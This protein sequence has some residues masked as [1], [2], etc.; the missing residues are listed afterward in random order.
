[1]DLHTT[2]RHARRWLRLGVVLLVVVA[3]ISPVAVMAAGGAFTDDDTSIFEA[4]IEWL[5]D[6]G[7]TAGC[8]P[9]DNDYFC[10]G[11]AVTRGQMAAF[12]RRLSANQVVDAGALGGETA[13]HFEN[14]VWANDVEGLVADPF[15]G[16]N[17][18]WVQLTVETTAPGFLLINATTSLYDSTSAGSALFWIQVDVPAC[19]NVPDQLYSVGYA[20]GYVPED[21]RQSV[22]ITGAAVVDA[23]THT[24]T[25]CGRSSAGGGD[26]RL[27]GPSLTALFTATGT[28]PAS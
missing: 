7:V 12:M 2:P 10:P 19:S 9:P 26:T 24:V 15:D 8:N 16:S 5:A 25:L 17:Q 1:M 13:D 14:A 23:G 4:D 6:A 28:V 20:Y 27:Y 3:V 18:E 21:Y 11:D 22:A